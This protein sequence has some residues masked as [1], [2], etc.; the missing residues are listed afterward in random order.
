MPQST[1]KSQ[2]H[3][4]QLGRQ[5]PFRT[6]SFKGDI[7]VDIGIFVSTVYDMKNINGGHA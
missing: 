7:I 4:T 6:S 1:Q 5:F 2:L 3:Q